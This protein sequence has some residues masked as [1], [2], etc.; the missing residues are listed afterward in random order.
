[1]ARRT[2]KC[3]SRSICKNDVLR[4]FTKDDAFL[5]MKSSIIVTDMFLDQYRNRLPAF[6]R[7]NMRF[8]N[9]TSCSYVLVHTQL[10]FEQDMQRFFHDETIRTL[11][12]PDKTYNAIVHRNTIHSSKGSL[13][14]GFTIV[15]NS[16]VLNDDKRCSFMLQHEQLGLRCRFNLTKHGWVSMSPMFV[17]LEINDLPIRFRRAQIL[18]YLMCS[19]YKKG[20]VLPSDIWRYIQSFIGTEPIHLFMVKN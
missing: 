8:V 16:V 3:S 20:I 15:E 13:V 4:R 12:L 19:Y 17:R 5:Y 11:S 18:S 10:V 2:Y 7:K 9:K 1:M 14:N 6:L